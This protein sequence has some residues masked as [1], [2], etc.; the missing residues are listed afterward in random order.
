[1]SNYIRST[2]GSVVTLPL[3]NSSNM[4]RGTELD[5]ETYVHVRWPWLTLPVLCVISALV[6]L[7]CVILQ[8]RREGALVWKSSVLAYLF[9]GLDQTVISETSTAEVTEMENAAAKVKMRLGRDFEG[10]WK[11]LTSGRESE[12]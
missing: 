7:I 6:L 4:V 8:T 3:F 5:M 2:G 9:H 1:M 10:N 12:R 11:L